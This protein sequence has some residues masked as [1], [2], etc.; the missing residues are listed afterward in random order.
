MS[1]TTEIEIGTGTVAVH[2]IFDPLP[3]FMARADCIFT[4][5]PY[6]QGMLKGFYTKAGKQPPF[7]FSRFTSRLFQC[8]DEIG[9]N[10]VFL[11][12]GRQHVEN[13][14]VRLQNRYKYVRSYDATYYHNKN[15]RCFILQA[16]LHAP[17]H[18]LKKTDEQD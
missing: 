18:E 8:I 15:N 9:P 10:S 11:E 13:F 7:D 4:D 5:P 2:D 12:I 6:N 1:V 17:E 3:S 16:T 14:K